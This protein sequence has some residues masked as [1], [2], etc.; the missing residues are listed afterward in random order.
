MKVDK[1]TFKKGDLV[2]NRLSKGLYR[3][4]KYWESTKEYPWGDE[5]ELYLYV[6]SVDGT[7]SPHSDYA[8]NFYPANMEQRD[9]IEELKSD[10]LRRLIIEQIKGS[11]D[12]YINATNDRIINVNVNFE[13]N[14]VTVI[15]KDL[16]KVDI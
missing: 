12:D 6:E 11:L 13:N 9:K 7:S 8:H 3:A 16:G 1:N 4:I 2:R 5:T 14:K 10:S 15:T